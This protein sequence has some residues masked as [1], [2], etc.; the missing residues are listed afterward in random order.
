MIGELLRQHAGDSR[1]KLQYAL[2]VGSNTSL[3]WSDWQMIA[4]ENPI[5][6]HWAIEVFKQYPQSR[7]LE[8]FINEEVAM[9][10]EDILNYNS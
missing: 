3:C 10:K 6:M 1:Q 8:S 2:S 5:Y 7:L 4:D 9:T